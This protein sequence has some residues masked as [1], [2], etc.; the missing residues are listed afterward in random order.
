MLILKH[1][2]CSMFRYKYAFI[3]IVF[4]FFGIDQVFAQS[5]YGY[6]IGK[7]SNENGFPIVDAKISFSNSTE[8]L[9]SDVDGKFD[10]KLAIGK[11]AFIF[12]QF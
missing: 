6:L 2:F 11:F 3:A 10:K 8:T 5:G 7:V 4:T 1:D 12:K 9:R